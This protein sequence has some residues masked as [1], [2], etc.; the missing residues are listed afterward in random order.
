MIKKVCFVLL[1]VAI[2]FAAVSCKTASK[3]GL[4]VE[5]EVKNYKY[6]IYADGLDLSFEIEGNPTTGYQWI[7]DTDEKALDESITLVSSEYKQNEAPEMMVGVGG[8]FYFDITFS[9]DGEF[10]LDFTY[11]RSWDKKDNPVYMTLTVKVE[12]NKI[13]E[14][15]AK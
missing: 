2:L 6:S 3:K 1:A 10:D 13:T 9:K 11:C 5:G 12:G 7:L 8:Y 15:A 14:V 4:S